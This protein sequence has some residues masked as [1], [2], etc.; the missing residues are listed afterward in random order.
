M[1]FF[2]SLYLLSIFSKI[3]LELTYLYNIQNITTL[4]VSSTINMICLDVYC[5]GFLLLYEIS[6]RAKIENKNDTCSWGSTCLDTILRIYKM[7]K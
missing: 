2:A 5:K 3:M 6:F 7:K 4:P 1:N